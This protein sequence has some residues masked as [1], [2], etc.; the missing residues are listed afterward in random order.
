V[1]WAFFRIAAPARAPGE[2]SRPAVVGWLAWRRSAA[3]GY[4][5]ASLQATQDS[6]FIAAVSTGGGSWNPFR[7]T[8][9]M[10]AGLDPMAIIMLKLDDHYEPLTRRRLSSNC[11]TYAPR[12][13]SGRREAVVN[14]ASVGA[15]L[16]CS[17]ESDPIAC[18]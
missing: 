15:E 2:P 14:A 5:Q 16:A 3:A 13:A 1:S 9:A 17:R 7:M 18:C 11:A 12:Y 8:H 10:I 4:G 6:G